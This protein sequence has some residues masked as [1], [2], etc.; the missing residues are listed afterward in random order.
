MKSAVF[1]FRVCEGMRI[2]LVECVCHCPTQIMTQGCKIMYRWWKNV[3]DKISVTEEV[4]Q[5][6]HG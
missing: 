5:R 1:P 3:T 6:I 4:T 2:V